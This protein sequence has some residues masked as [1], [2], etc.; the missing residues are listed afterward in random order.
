MCNDGANRHTLVV[1]RSQETALKHQ[2]NGAIRF[3]TINALVDADETMMRNLQ[4]ALSVKHKGMHTYST[5]DIDMHNTVNLISLMRT[6]RAAV[7]LATRSHLSA[8][9]E[10]LC[11]LAGVFL[12][13]RARTNKAQCCAVHVTRLAHEHM[14]TYACHFRS[15][16]C[17]PPGS[18][19]LPCTGRS[20]AGPMA[21]SCLELSRDSRHVFM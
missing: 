7:V 6:Y 10:F 12:H 8:T 3:T 18:L 11:G 5:T 21:I 4:C 1:L 14:R 15:R 13:C 20:A 17:S 2:Q 19:G 16:V 9:A